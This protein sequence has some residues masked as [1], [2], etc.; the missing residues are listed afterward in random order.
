MEHHDVQGLLQPYLLL[1]ANS[2]DN[3]IFRRCLSL[4]SPPKSKIVKTRD[5]ERLIRKRSKSVTE[6]TIPSI[7][8][9]PLDRRNLIGD[10][11]APHSLPIIPG[12]HS[13]LAYITSKF[14]KMGP[15]GPEKPDSKNEFRSYIG[16]YSEGF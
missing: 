5:Q 16:K 13:D 9:G 15:F 4:S 6:H 1:K 2:S 8:D 11:S 12:R 14:K 7:I 10:F 3:F